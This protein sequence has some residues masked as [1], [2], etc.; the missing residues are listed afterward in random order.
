M[1]IIFNLYYYNTSLQSI[2]DLSLLNFK[3]GDY[4]RYTRP[5]VNILGSLEHIRVS[6]N[7]PL[8]VTDLKLSMAGH[9]VATVG[10]TVTD[11]CWLELF[12]DYKKL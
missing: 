12:Q 1:K 7:K 6:E 9:V 5:A 11:C 4:V 3:K 8:L 2:Y 10:G